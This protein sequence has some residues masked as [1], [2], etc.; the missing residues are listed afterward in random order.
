MPN[1]KNLV[2][3]KQVFFTCLIMVQIA[4]VQ[5]PTKVVYAEDSAVSQLSNLIITA[6]QITGGTGHTQEDF[7]ELYNPTSQ[8]I[9][10]SG[11]RLVKRTAAGVTDT[12]IKSWSDSTVVAPHHFYLWA[13]SSFSA[14]TPAADTTS[15]GTLADNNGIALRFGAS[16]T[17]TVID[18]L[19][20]GT[21]TN[22]F[23]NVSSVNPTANE[24][25]IRENVFA[26][27]SGYELKHSAPRNS[28]TELLPELPPEPEEIPE[29]LLPEGEIPEET[30]EAEVPPVILPDPIPVPETSIPIEPID[31]KIT[32]LLPNPSSNDSGFE[33]VELYN[34]GTT[35]VNLKDFKLDDVSNTDAISSNSYS[36]ED[37]DIEPQSYLA[38]VIPTGKFSLNNTEGDIVTL[39][40]STNKSLDSVS[41]EED[42]PE[43]E[44][45]SFFESGWAW[46]EPTFG[47]VNLQKEEESEETSEEEDG[48]LKHSYNNSDLIISEVYSQPNSNEQEFIEIYNSGEETALL[49]D[50]DL[51][52]GDRH[53][54]L[55]EEELKAGEYFVIEQADLP[56]QL[57][58]S[59]QEVRLRQ[60]DT[61]IDS[62]VY[63]TGLKGSSYSLFE[64]GFLWTTKTTK[65]QKNVL[66]LQKEVVKTTTTPVKTT[67]KSPTKA[68]AKPAVKK[69]TS[70]KAVSKTT[71]TPKTSTSKNTTEK[72]A[73]KPVE[74]SVNTSKQKA[75]TNESVGKIIAMGAASVA[76]AIAAL[77]KFVFSGRIE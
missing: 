21:T 10:L 70:T 11:Y 7:V 47:A 39:F 48:S 6:V 26:L 73:E 23:S 3:L 17:G 15:S 59:G 69:S 28:L 49:S 46:A 40:D 32:E 56:I 66:E 58:N 42:S 55:S 8:S 2:R 13:N 62:V 75:I 71:N 37:I 9:D 1:R 30:L 67:A 5:L 64:D 43:N 76:A 20:W 25:L 54:Q 12:L 16:D 57:R 24:S 53:R 18:Y 41:Y 65:G 77:Y 29:E 38:I 27:S 72:N 14:I 68:T 36:L 60:G 33:Q 35:S 4:F 31:I 50:V 45:W 52:I 19:S 63:S 61:L 22:T 34:N 74:S 44:S 51:Y